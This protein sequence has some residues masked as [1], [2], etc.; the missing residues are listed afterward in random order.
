MALTLIVAYDIT[1]DNRRAKLAALL[2]M[3]G[4]RLQYSV[5]LISITDDDFAQL[6]D[7]IL[8]IIKPEEDSVF[9]LRQCQSC[10]KAHHEIGQA[11]TA[12]ETLYWAAL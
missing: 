1:R 11:H 9:F 3:W 10:W 6:R 7:R 2:Q 4:D 5:F 12:P 8:D